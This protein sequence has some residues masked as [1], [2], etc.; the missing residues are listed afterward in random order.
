MVVAAGVKAFVDWY[1]AYVS[2]NLISAGILG[3]LRIG[4]F[5][6]YPIREI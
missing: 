3:F 5:V 4:Q 1:R 6:Q 2:A